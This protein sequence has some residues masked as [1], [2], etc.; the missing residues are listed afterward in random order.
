MTRPVDIAKLDQ[1]VPPDGSTVREVARP[2]AG[3]ANQSLAEATVPPGKDTAEH[4]HRETEEIYLFVA[5]AGRMKLGEET[6]DVAAG[7]AVVIPPGSAHK[8][9][10][11]GGEPLVLFCCCSPAYADEDTVL[12]E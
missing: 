7:Q 10:N 2:G 4:L 8:L 5:G 6:F 3:A 11:P 1:I 12:I 9:W